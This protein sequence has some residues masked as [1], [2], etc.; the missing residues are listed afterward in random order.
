[1]RY[2]III[3]KLMLCIFPVYGQ[4]IITKRNAELF[5]TVGKEYGSDKISDIPT[6]SQPVT[7][8]IILHRKFTLPVLDIA[9]SRSVFNY[10]IYI[11]SYK[12]E[13]YYIESK[14]VVDNYILDKKNK[15][16]DSLNNLYCRDTSIL[17]A[18]IE[19]ERLQDIN[20]CRILKDRQD[21]IQARVDF[22]D[23]LI[24]EKIADVKKKRE[25]E[26]K[27]FME[28][29]PKIKNFMDERVLITTLKLDPPNSAGGCDVEFFYT[30]MYDNTIKYLRWIGTIYNAVSD[31]VTCEISGESS[32]TFEDTGPYA[33]S[34]VGGGVWENVIYN[35][36]AKEIRLNSISIE[37]MDG[38]RF[39][40]SFDNSEAT[41][42]Q[43]ILEKYD[44]NVMFSYDSEV[45]KI[46]K[47]LG[48][49]EIYQELIR[50]GFY[51]DILEKKIE[52]IYGYSLSE[53][54]LEMRSEINDRYDFFLKKGVYVPYFD[55]TLLNCYD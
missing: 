24:I 51:I 21:S 42:I 16:V 1:M 25:S 12:G 4:E 26:L 20:E 29:Y 31:P 55:V 37:Y 45:R 11:V 44:R 47:E 27:A 52:N 23:S 22:M 36:S 49:N 50:I 32:F 41:V 48:Y 54:F 8:D 9:F 10:D 34:D 2:V 30:N 17:N 13:T 5:Y 40:I 3:I 28:R 53:D 14:D 38:A 46:K 35:Y 19:K 43:R 6:F 18:K 15:Q 7:A 33:K 39:S